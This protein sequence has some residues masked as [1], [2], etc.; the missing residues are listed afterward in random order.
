MARSVPDVRFGYFAPDALL[1]ALLELLLGTLLCLVVLRYPNPTPLRLLRRLH[2]GSVNDY[3]TML[4][5]G[6]VFTGFVLLL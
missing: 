6:T 4:T 5:V 1:P 3:A 2:T